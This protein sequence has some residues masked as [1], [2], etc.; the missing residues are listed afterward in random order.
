[1]VDIALAHRLRTA[2][3]I[4]ASA[5]TGGLMSF[6]SDGPMLFRRA[7][8]FVHKIIVRGEKP[9]DIPV[10]QTKFELVINLKTA[11]RSA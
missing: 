8:T 9:R 5:E 7:A 1:M 3:I 6:G 11:R 2:R 10:E 4:R